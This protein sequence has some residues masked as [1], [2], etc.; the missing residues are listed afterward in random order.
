MSYQEIL[1]IWNTFISLNNMS[2]ATVEAI[3]DIRVNN[4]KTPGAK[5]PVPV[6]RGQRGQRPREQERNGC[7][8]PEETKD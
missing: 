4:N 1:A 7:P 2:R 5:A 6:L 3:L 8:L